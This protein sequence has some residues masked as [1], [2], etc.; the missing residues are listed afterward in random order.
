MMLF[1]PNVG[2]G[3]QMAKISLTDQGSHPI[4]GRAASFEGRVWL[5]LREAARVSESATI[6]LMSSD[7]MV[8]G[9]L[10]G[11]GLRSKQVR[12]RSPSPRAAERLAV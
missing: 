8:H 1:S 12:S 10:L 2:T 11:D 7:S 9:D 3:A 4:Q 5:F 6:W